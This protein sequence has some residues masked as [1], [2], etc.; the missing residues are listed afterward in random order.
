M[1]RLD[2]SLTAGVVLAVLAVGM[3]APSPAARRAPADVPHSADSPIVSRFAGSII[4]AYQKLNY[5]E[6]AFPMGP[7]QG[8]EFAKTQATEGVVTRIV[9]AAP[10]GK[11]AAEVLVNFRDSL[12]GSGFNLLYSCTSGSG[13]NGCG[14]DNFAHSYADPL[15]SQDGEHR[16]LMMDLL[17][18]SEDDV[19]YLL[20]ELRH[21]GRTVDV[22]VMVAKN[23]SNPTGVL[24][25]VVENGQ[26]PAGQVNVDAAAMSKGLQSEG[27]VSLYGLQ[28]ETDS[29]TL[30]ADSD[31]TLKQISDLLHQ[32]PK[33]RVYIVGHTDNTGS[34]DHNLALSQHRAES[35]VKALTSRFGIAG[36]RLS[37]KGLASYS[38]LA[39]NHTEV[40]KARNRRVEI[41]EQ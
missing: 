11:T 2:I 38:P 15:L 20:A 4:I 23:G 32:Q 12:Q 33:L 13:E 10:L 19:R 14:G 7:L 30:S 24:L 18:S 39:N 37:A 41:V 22:G 40:D 16:D 36:E 5:D 29:A 3:A 17:F 27:K 6:V 35:V 26:M 9:Y 8:A 21:D 34:L 1:N 31:G 25:Q 28:F